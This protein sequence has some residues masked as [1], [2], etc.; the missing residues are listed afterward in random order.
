MKGTKIGQNVLIIFLVAIGFI[1]AQGDYR[2]Y[3]EQEKKNEEKPERLIQMA[4]EFP[5]VVI[6]V[7]EVVNMDIIF[8]NK[9]RS[10]ENVEAWVASV[11]EGWTARIKTYKF[12]VTSIYVPSGENKRLTFEAEPG[13]DLK[14]GDYKFEVKAQTPDGQFKMD[15]TIAVRVK[16]KE[17]KSK[18][19]RGVRLTT[20][21]PVLKGPPDAK[22]EFSIEVDSKLDKEAVFNLFAQGPEGWDINFKPAY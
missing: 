19:A 18:E 17:E 11:A 20:S 22:F 3:G 2:V 6:S 14:P 5:G 8:H 4:V 1:L 7:D 15:Q 10:D 13:K 9:G 16:A 12:G 21:Y